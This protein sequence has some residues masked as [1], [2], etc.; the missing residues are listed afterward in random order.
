VCSSL[1]LEAHVP[2]ARRSIMALAAV[3]L[4]LSACHSDGTGPSSA[5]AGLYVLTS[6]RG[7]GPITG[8]MALSP[9]GDVERRVR[10]LLPSGT[11]SSE[12]VAIGTYQQ[13]ADGMLDLR[14]REDPNSSI[15]WQPHAQLR[16]GM[17]Q[18]QYPAAADGPDVIETYERQ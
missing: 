7:S 12:Y 10:Y 6:V 4:A 5:L 15:A 2:H 18:L 3:V 16:F 11:V 14:L 17:L 9:T 1:R 13:R 8:A